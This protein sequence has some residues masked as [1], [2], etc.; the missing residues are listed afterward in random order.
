MNWNDMI[1][2]NFR[3]L[4]LLT[5]SPVSL[6]DISL[7]KYNRGSAHKELW[8][9]IAGVST[10]WKHQNTLHCSRPAVKSES[11]QFLSST[12]SQTKR[13]GKSKETIRSI[14][15]TI[16][17]AIPRAFQYKSFISIKCTNILIITTVT[18]EPTFA[19]LSSRPLFPWSTSCAS[20]P[21]NYTLKLTRDKESC[22][23]LAK[24]SDLYT[25]T[26]HDH[27]K[28]YS[29]SQIIT[30]LQPFSAKKRSRLSNSMQ[31][32]ECILQIYDNRYRHKH[33]PIASTSRYPLHRP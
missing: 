12:I 15:A 14:R 4:H 24:I 28:R 2:T 5:S 22:F 29:Y 13:L 6:C 27:S 9:S 21:T 30:L 11:R 23:L 3:P 26:M 16:S 33:I 19:D 1:E 20:I 32:W 31:L 8:I 10:R 18:I 7:V 25:I 17:A